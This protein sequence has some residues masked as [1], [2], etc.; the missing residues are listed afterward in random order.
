[1]RASNGRPPRISDQL[2]THLFILLDK[3]NLNS[4]NYEI[5]K[6]RSLNVI[7]FSGHQ[8]L[9]SAKS[10]TNYNEPDAFSLLLYFLLILHN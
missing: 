3:S 2:I 9:L 8:V 6:S 5:L 10:I 1:M 4:I 7:N